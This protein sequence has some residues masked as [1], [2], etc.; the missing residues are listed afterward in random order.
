MVV[1]DHCVGNVYFEK[2][3]AS[4]ASK[5][6]LLSVPLNALGFFGDY[7]ECFKFDWKYWVDIYIAS[8]SSDLQQASN[9][10]ISDSAYYL[11]V[12]VAVLFV[13]IFIYHVYNGINKFILKKDEQIKQQ[14]HIE[15]PVTNTSYYQA[16]ST[17]ILTDDQAVPVSL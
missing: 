2:V 1:F 5:H 12:F 4:N 9:T 7:Y 10:T 16:V 8:K 3:S 13:L 14:I 11:T 17:E 6:C 15:I